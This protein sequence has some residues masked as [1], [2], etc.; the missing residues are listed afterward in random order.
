MGHI[1][2]KLRVYS[3]KY[4]CHVSGYLH[5]ACKEKQCLIRSI[6]QEAWNSGEMVLTRSHFVAETEEYT[7]TVKVSSH[8]GPFYAML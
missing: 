5:Y 2:N 3:D 8:T 1:L 4:P 6:K 7:N